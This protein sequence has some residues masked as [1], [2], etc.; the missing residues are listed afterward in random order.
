M[1]KQRKLLEKIR[2]TLRELLLEGMEIKPCTPINLH[3][4]PLPDYPYKIRGVVEVESLFSPKWDGETCTLCGNRILPSFNVPDK[5]W[6]RVM[7]GSPFTFCL[8]CFDREAQ[9]K[10]VKYSI[11]G[12]FF[13]GEGMREVM[14]FENGR[15]E[16]KEKKERG[17]R[18]KERSENP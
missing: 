15:F 10:G 12:F 3:H 16:V 8:P 9:K 2:E 7:E 11:E 5:V 1:K 18:E 4:P 13:V 6:E 17:G 14:V